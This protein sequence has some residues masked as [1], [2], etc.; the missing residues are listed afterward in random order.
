MLT[1]AR[2]TG[3]PALRR[4][5]LEVRAEEL[6][7]AMGLRFEPNFPVGRFVADFYL[8]DHRIVVECYGPLHRKRQD[9]IQRDKDRARV[10]AEAGYRLVILSDLDMHLWWRSL[11]DAT[12]MSGI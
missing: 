3:R 7:E 9:A 10:V 5:N 1:L 4:S 6:F 2:E 12:S 11:Q 8:P